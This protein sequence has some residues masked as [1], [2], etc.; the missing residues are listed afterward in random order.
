MIAVDSSVVV[1]AFASW[2]ELHRQALLVLDRGPQLP[3]QAALETYSVLTRLPAPHRAAPGLVRDFIERNFGRAVI[4]LPAERVPALLNEL[5]RLGISGGATYDAVIGATARD[6][7]RTLVTF[8]ERARQ[9]YDRLGVR[10]EY[11]AP[12][13]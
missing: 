9:T 10:I 7:G 1:A 6:G 3:V 11:V 8:D 5:V 12:A 2:H 4:G 13:G